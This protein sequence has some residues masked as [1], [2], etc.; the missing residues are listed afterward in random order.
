MRNYN[1]KMWPS[2]FLAASLLFFASC[3]DSATTAN[4]DSNQPESEKSSTSKQT[5]EAYWILSGRVITLDSNA[6][7]NAKVYLTDTDDSTGRGYY[8]DSATTDKNGYYLFDREKDKHTY[9]PYKYHLLV[10]AKYAKDSLYAFYADY[11]RYHRVYEGTEDSLY[12]PIRVRKYVTVLM[13][14]HKFGDLYSSYGS[15][16]ES[17]ADS[18]CFGANFLC[19]TFSKKDFENNYFVSIDN[20]PAGEISDMRIWFGKYPTIISTSTTVGHRDTVIWGH[21]IGGYPEDTLQITLPKEAAKMLDSMGLEPSLDFLLAPIHTKDE[22]ARRLNDSQD[23]CFDRL[24]AGNGYEVELIHAENDD[25]ANRFWGMFK[26]MS[27]N[28]P[29]SRWLDNTYVSK[30]RYG[31][32]RGVHII[33]SVEPGF[34]LP[35]TL[36]KLHKYTLSNC[37]MVFYK[38]A[39]SNANQVASSY[40]D[41]DCEGTTEYESRDTAFLASFWIDTEEATADFSKILSAGEKVGFEIARCEDDSKSICFQVNTGIDSSSKIYGTSKIFD[42]KKHHVAFVL[43]N[44]HLTIAIDGETITDSVLELSQEFYENNI[45]GIKVGDFALTDFIIHRYNSDFQRPDYSDWRRM[46][47]WLKAFYLLQK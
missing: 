43:Y 37:P 4:E 45:S 32:P 11:P 41:D 30:D 25:D 9:I 40:W 23:Y 33:A 29:V 24:L 7:P 2:I 38:K 8:I 16:A 18:I 12:I 46:R 19:H 6:V 36:Y 1:F 28:M 20:F 10:R 27:K 47:V 34:T 42:G 26:E 17:Y 39:N 22:F 35:D 21:E 44:E 13:S 3:S 14:T 5:K 15:S 31:L